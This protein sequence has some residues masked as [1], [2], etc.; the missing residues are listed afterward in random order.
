MREK[1][2][3]ILSMLIFGAV[4][5]F[6]KYIDLAASEIALF[7]SLIG[8]LFLF[9]ISIGT[10]QNI[11]WQTMKKNAP[12][13]LLSSI[14]LGGNWIFLFQSY[15]ETTIANAALS[16][17]FAP[18]LVIVLSPIVLKEKLSLKRAICVGTALFGLLLIVQ[19]GG[20]EGAGHHLL[21]IVYGLI[22]AAFYAILTLTNKFIR[23]M[24]G[25]ESTLSQLLLSSVWLI[26]YVL[27]T[28]GFELFRIS[29]N[30][31]ILILILGVLHTGVG[32]YLFFSGMRGLEG[33]SIAVLS[34]IDAVASLLISAFVIG[35]RMTLVQMLG[36]VLLL[37]STFISEASRNKKSV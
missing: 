4:G 17:Y 7:M 29:G 31:M 3:F 36:A 6:A 12:V 32:F 15:K 19:S 23:G 34:Y 25:L 35:E 14:A 22:A 20:K 33:Q 37:G 24:N 11:S 28:E 30:S 5:V 27:M 21:G 8:S 1:I 2:Y 10:K 13:L 18:V 9:V 16:Y 26:P